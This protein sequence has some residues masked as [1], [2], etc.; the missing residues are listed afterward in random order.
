M[1]EAMVAHEPARAS[2]R[3]ARET[4]VGTQ[5]VQPVTYTHGIMRPI[6]AR[7]NRPRVSAG[8]EQQYEE[9]E[10]KNNRHSSGIGGGPGP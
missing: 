7:R 9:K 10:G 8:R 6:N 2:T 3:G 5:R 1:R 4:R